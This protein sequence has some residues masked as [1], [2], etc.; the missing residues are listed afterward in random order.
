MGKREIIDCVA[1]GGKLAVELSHMKESEKE[2]WRCGIDAAA[3]ILKK[4]VQ[5]SPVAQQMRETAR[6]YDLDRIV[7]FPCLINGIW[8]VLFRMYGR[9]VFPFCQCAGIQLISESNIPMAASYLFELEK[10]YGIV[11]YDRQR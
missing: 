7:A 2:E 11:L 6:Q 3:T 9:E 4:G 1:F 5:E 10:Q 8:V